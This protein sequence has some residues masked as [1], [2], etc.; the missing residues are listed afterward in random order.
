MRTTK[1]TIGVLAI[2]GLIMAGSSPSFAIDTPSEGYKLTSTPKRIQMSVG[3]WD[4]SGNSLFTPTKTNQEWS[5]FRNWL[6]NHAN[7]ATL[8]VCATCSDGIQ[9]QGETGV[10]CGGPCPACAAAPTCSD[11][12]QNQGETGIDCGGPC[13]PCGVAPTCSDGVQN[14]GETGVDCGGPC[15]ACAAAPTCSDGIQNQGET[16]IDCGGPCAACPPS[17]PG[18]GCVACGCP[19][20]QYC[21]S[22]RIGDN[23]CYCDCNA[24]CRN[25]G[26]SSCCGSAG[27]GNADVSPWGGNWSTKCDGLTFGCVN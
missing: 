1:W 12:I 15:P 2:T 4:A 6:T 26:Y 24:V 13:P 22:G 16:G 20:F 27:C 3:C 10:D 23:L 25:M 18:D 19:A 8:I 5:G 11:G 14:Q 9:N 17:C 21:N 7:Q